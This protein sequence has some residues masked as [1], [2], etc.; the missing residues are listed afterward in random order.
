MNSRSGIPHGRSIFGLASVVAIA[1]AAFLAGRSVEDHIAV[2]AA[3][4]STGEPANPA[5]GSVAADADDP[6]AEVDRAWQQRDREVDAIDAPAGV[7][8]RR[9]WIAD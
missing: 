3:Q 9:E 1:A 8:V 6:L 2:V 5:A 7:E 4:P